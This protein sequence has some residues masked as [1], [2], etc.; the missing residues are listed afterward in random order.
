MAF[1]KINGK[2]LEAKCNFRFERLAD[3]KY[4]DKDKEGNEVGGF[5]S[6]YSNL[7]QYSNKHLLAFFDCG[8]DYLVKEKPSLED[9]EA[10]IEARI[11]E[12]GDTE[13][14]FKEAFTAVD[15]SGFFKKQAKSYWK[16][17]NAFKES[18][19]DK[20]EQEKNA[21]SANILID[22]YKEVTGRD[23][24]EGITTNS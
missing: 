6:L 3:K 15:E 7:L 18:G 4:S 12:D 24:L 21:K 23:P 1:L 8:F 17:I 13:E 22:A 14:L 11:E 16:N 9:I 20:E 5:H 2:E 10:A 19:K